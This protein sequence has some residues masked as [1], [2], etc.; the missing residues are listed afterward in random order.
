[1][2]HAWTAS[3][4]VIERWWRVCDRLLNAQAGAGASVT[5]E[6]YDGPL[7]WGGAT[8]LVQPGRWTW[9]WARRTVLRSTCNTA[10]PRLGDP[11]RRGW[12]QPCPKVSPESR[13]ARTEWLPAGALDAVVVDARPAQLPWHR[14]ACSLATAPSRRAC[15]GR[16]DRYSDCGMDRICAAGQTR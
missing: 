16:C 6:R 2:H 10:G 9:A 1:V 8:W 12:R 11:S 15:L 13:S 7:P 4:A 3:R 5:L 14:R